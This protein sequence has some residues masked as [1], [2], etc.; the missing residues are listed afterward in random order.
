[1]RVEECLFFSNSK[2]ISARVRVPDGNGPFPAVVIN[3]GYSGD[4]QEYDAMA[5]VL[6]QGGYLTLQ[7]DSRGCGE[8]EA[9]FGAMMCSSEWLEDAISAVSYVSAL[10]KTDRDR[11]GYAGCSMGGAVTVYMAAMDHRV[12]AA[13]AM[14]P[15][16]YGPEMMEIQWTENR[17]R[18]A[19]LEFLSEMEEDLEHTSKGEAS[20]LVS[21]PYAL[22]MTKKDED[23]YL[24]ERSLHSEM[25]SHVPLS[26][27]FNS[28]MVFRP[29]DL[30]PRISIPM[31]IL[32]GNHDTLVPMRHSKEAIKHLNQECR[33]TVIEGGVHALPTCEKSPE[34]FQ[35]TKNWFD[36]HFL[37]RQGHA[38][39]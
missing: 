25:V 20:R 14:A 5:S 21:V 8:S 30:C 28:F 18:A 35:H 10:E 11:I 15:V 31:L 23:E 9:A 33:L 1:M 38:D 39:G 29:G 27:V 32:H 17:G 7:F 12:K 6:A 3:H 2:R 26:S 37:N 19:Y 4:K 34:V 22:G 24:A 16:L 36:R 13:V